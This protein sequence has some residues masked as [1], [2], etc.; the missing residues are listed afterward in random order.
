[1]SEQ[2]TTFTFTHSSLKSKYVRG[3]ENRLSTSSINEVEL[4]LF[5][6]ISDVELLRSSSPSNSEVELRYSPS[7]V[8]EVDLLLLAD[9]DLPDFEEVEL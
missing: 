5:V 9:E 7:T 8:R 3:Y 4:V 2:S 6:S 1:M